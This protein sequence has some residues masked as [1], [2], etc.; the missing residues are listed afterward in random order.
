[1]KILHVVQIL[2][3][4]GIEQL[5]L[6]MLK[7]NQENT[8]IFILQGSSEESIINFPILEKFQDSIF[9]AHLEKNGKKHTTSFLRKICKKYNITA[10]H[11][12]Y[13]GPLLYARLA[14]I[15]LKNIHH[16]HT[17]HDAWHLLSFKNRILEKILMASKKKIQLVAVSQ[18]IQTILPTYFPHK[19]IHLI[20]NGI[21]TT[22]FKPKD[23][24]KARAHF[25]LP[26]SCILIASAGSLI[27]LKGHA[28][29]IKAMLELPENYQLAIAGKGFLF[30]EL[31]QLIHQLNL[32]T[33]V[34]LLGPVEDMPLFY[35]ACDLYC[36]PSIDEG[37]P[38]ALLEAQA[39]N[40]PAISSNVGSCFEAIDKAS[41]L[42]I[43]AQ[44]SDAIAKAC[45]MLQEKKGNP[46]EFIIQNFS[47]D[48]LME[49]YN[50]LYKGTPHDTLD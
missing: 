42:L 31:S 37:L 49:K 32:N 17:E 23:Q 48:T 40:L 43:E 9:F 8:Y 10:I 6:A 28:F 4:G 19:K 1:M 14:T 25:K 46:R 30:E 50:R 45:L 27:P 26:P 47:L 5:V 22:L 35:Q 39:T 21:D 11:T 24:I 41:G 3:I 13:N 36:H 44:D 18:K 38:L 7:K 29:L 20:Y 15:G 16:V 12:H 34:H 33:R 2:S